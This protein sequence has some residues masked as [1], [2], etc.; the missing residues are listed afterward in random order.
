MSLES[1]S[2]AINR[3][4]GKS[5]CFLGLPSTWRTQQPPVGGQRVPWQ[6][7]GGKTFTEVRRGG[8]ASPTGLAGGGGGGGGG[9]TASPTVMA[10]PR[11]RLQAG[12]RADLEGA[13]PG[14]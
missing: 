12:G 13:L 8:T 14:D 7:G 5:L 3:L 6:R 2:S 9:G 11:W 1:T 10:G 4:H